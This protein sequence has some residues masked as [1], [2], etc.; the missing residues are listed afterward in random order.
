MAT[1]DTLSNA[2]GQDTTGAGEQTQ[3]TAE[4]VKPGEQG[5]Q[6]TDQGNPDDGQNTD[7][8]G[9]EVPEKYEFSMPEGVE[10]DAAAADEFTSIAK[11]L[12]LSQADAQKVADVGAKMAQRQAEKHQATVQSWVEAV[13][14]DKDIGG[15]KLNENMAVAR[16]AIETYGSPELKDVLNATGL[17]NH[18]A[19]VKAFYAI[20]KTLQSDT[21]VRGGTTTGDV[22]PAKKLFPNMN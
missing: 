17:G 4:G 3:Q 20:G 9:T 1:E 16:K 5:E 21:I 18:P 15:D 7:G 6:T 11:D 10:L 19:F 22:D 14:S 12:K 8:K 13:K 2:S